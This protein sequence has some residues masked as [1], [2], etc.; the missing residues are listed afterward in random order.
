LQELKTQAA[1]AGINLDE[2]KSEGDPEEKLNRAKDK[3][4]D[5]LRDFPNDIDYLNAADCE[6]K[7]RLT[8]NPKL[9]LP[10]KQKW[11]TYRK[12]CCL[13][14]YGNVA[15]RCS[16]NNTLWGRY[17]TSAEAG[18]PL[19]LDAVKAMVE[20]D[21]IRRELYPKDYKGHPDADPPKVYIEELKRSGKYTDILQ[22]LN[23][24]TQRI[25]NSG[26]Q[27]TN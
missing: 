1:F 3:L 21:A 22:R 24:L 17:L 2:D 13:G 12:D 26:S 7:I 5:P 10:F 25:Q 15:K 19:P 14:K 23:T 8:N 20:F 18:R 16:M 4:K 6:V 9:K 27:S 11:D